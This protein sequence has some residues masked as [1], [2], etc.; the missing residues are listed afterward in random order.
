MKLD[1]TFHPLLFQSSLAAGGVA[2]MPFNFLQFSIPH[3]KGMITLSQ[4]MTRSLTGSEMGL[5]YPLIAVM[6]IFILLHFF[7]T[8]VFLKDFFA[9]FARKEEYGKFI[10]NPYANVGIFAIIS[11]LAMSANVFW[12][13][14]GFFVP[15]VSEN[16]QGLMLPS[17]IFFSVL[18]VSLIRLE[19]RV[20][21]SWV[22]KSVDMK[23]FNF[24][25]L[26][27]AFS[28]G[29]VNLTGTGIAT[30]AENPLISLTAAFMSTVTLIVGTLF[31]VLKLT[32]LLRT[33]MS[34]KAMPDKPILPAYF[35]VV[36][37]LCLFGLS[38]YRLA[39]FAQARY[40]IDV[41]GLSYV[42]INFSYIATIVWGMYCIYFLSDYFR[43]HF[44]Q[45][46]FSPP[47]WGMV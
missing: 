12:A 16:L 42:F 5:Y 10:E 19:F 7:L 31:F 33:Q 2:L 36:P 44:S 39:N 45:S 43:N 20:M 37:I 25:W 14:V 13:P 32:F 28:F 18:W 23:K 34:A 46:D 6:L 24:I 29:L 41:S 9:W 35:L 47:Q 40:A 11:S 3:G 30:M 8:A 15:S 17:L 21:K 38:F 26:L 4:V 27:D 1:K 22:A